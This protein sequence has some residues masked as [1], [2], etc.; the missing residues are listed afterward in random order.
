MS[1]EQV[2]KHLHDQIKDKTLKRVMLCLDGH[3]RPESTREAVA[4]SIVDSLHRG[5]L[6]SVCVGATILGK[7]ISIVYED[8][9]TY[10]PAHHVDG[11]R[12][13]AYTAWFRLS[14][15]YEDYIQVDRNLAESGGCSVDEYRQRALAQKLKE[16]GVSL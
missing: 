2:A 9:G 16:I 1:A 7:P 11:T 13:E 4:K 12:F 6:S 5:S 15:G 3:V 10:V 14:N 8:K